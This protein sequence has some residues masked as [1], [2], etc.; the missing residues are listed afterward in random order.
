MFYMSAVE[1]VNLCEKGQ[2]SK[3]ADKR[4]T[5]SKQ[6]AAQSKQNVSKGLCFCRYRQ[7]GAEQKNAGL[8]V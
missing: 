5:K 4:A 7:K 8:K 1:K 6:L 2:A 3:N